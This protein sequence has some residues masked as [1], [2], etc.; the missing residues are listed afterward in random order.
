MVASKKNN[1]A[2]ATPAQN[3]QPVAVEPQ[4]AAGTPALL[5]HRG[6]L[7]I[8]DEV[9][10]RMG[11]SP[12]HRHLFVADFEW[13]VEPPLALK[14]ARIFRNPNKGTD[15]KAESSASVESACL[16][17]LRKFAINTIMCCALSSC[18]SPNDENLKMYIDGMNIVGMKDSEA[19]INLLSKGFYCSETSPVICWRSK[20]SYIISVCREK[21]WLYQ[22]E[23]RKVSKIEVGHACQM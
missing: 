13:L 7:F 8:Q 9:T 19:I 11:R 21:V 10:W 1:G 5:N 6:F 22:D 18:Y 23:N 17:K 14:Q 3:P 12:R 20:N 2:V 4:K 16:Y 15:Q